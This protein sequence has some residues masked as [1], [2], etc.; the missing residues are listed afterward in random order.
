MLVYAVKCEYIKNNSNSKIDKTNIQ[1]YTPDEVKKLITALYQDSI[2]YQS[3]VML[4]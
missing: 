3:L 4:H 1:F 2:K